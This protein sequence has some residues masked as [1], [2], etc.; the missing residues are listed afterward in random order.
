LTMALP[1]VPLA[2]IITIFM[3]VFPS[4]QAKIISNRT[5]IARKDGRTRRRP[6][7]RPYDQRRHQ[8]NENDPASVNS[9]LQ[10]SKLS[11]PLAKQRASKILIK[12]ARPF[13]DDR[14]DIARPVSD[15]PK[16]GANATPSRSARRSRLALRSRA[17]RN[18]RRASPEANGAAPAG[19]IFVR[20]K[21]RL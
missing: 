12:A 7:K 10:D 18:G 16:V 11:K 2:P 20:H 9:D 6:A 21:R 4:V 13:L 17:E 3:P 5:I 1:I 8:G 15:V 14:S 19:E